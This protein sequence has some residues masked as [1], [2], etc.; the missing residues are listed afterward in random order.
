MDRWICTPFFVARPEDGLRDVAG[1]DWI[2]NAP[3]LAGDDP[4]ARMAALYAPL[5]GHVAE[6]LEAGDRPVSFAGD[7]LSS[8]AVLAGL[9]RAGIEATLL[10]FDA[11]GDFNTPETTPSGFLGGMPLAMAVGRG[12]LRLVEALGLSP[13]P[14]SSVIL[15]DARD[16]DPGER[17]AVAG[18]RLTHVPDVAL[19]L[20]RPPPAGP[21]HVHFDTDIVD[22]AESPA[23]NYPV[24]GGPSAALMERV[25][26]HVGGHG[27]VVAV[28]V[29]AWNPSLPGAGESRAI[30]MALI[31]ALL[32]GARSG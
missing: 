17:E 30:S 4:I 24:A 27:N 21:L 3:A 15:T 26:R 31:E 8:L 28:S 2:V 1:R 12:N 23:Q 22:A 9:E 6:I 11:H 25:F 19:L 16:L 32:G 10:W 18:S 13:I 14:E 20:E 29:S 5:A 7:C